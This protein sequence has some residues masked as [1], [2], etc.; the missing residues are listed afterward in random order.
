MANYVLSNKS[1]FVSYLTVHFRIRFNSREQQP[2]AEAWCEKIQ[3]MYE[4]WSPCLDFSLLRRQLYIG[5]FPGQN[6]RADML[7]DGKWGV[8]GSV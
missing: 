7:S 8:M 3:Q 4:N 6:K 5:A 2:E 1:S